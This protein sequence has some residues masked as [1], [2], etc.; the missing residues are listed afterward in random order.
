[1]ERILMENFDADDIK[2]LHSEGKKFSYLLE[3]DGELIF[4]IN[5]NKLK[6]KVSKS[7]G[8]RISE[9]FDVSFEDYTDI[10]ED[11]KG[12]SHI[13][14]G[15]KDNRDRYGRKIIT[16]IEFDAYVEEFGINKLKMKKDIKI[17]KI[18]GKDVESSIWNISWRI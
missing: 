3:D 8:F 10:Y 14:V 13:K 12:K 6:E 1:M 7:K 16:S 11:D 4:E 18:N 5:T 2:A 9:G 15:T 17:K